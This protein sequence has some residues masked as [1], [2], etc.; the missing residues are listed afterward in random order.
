MVK[1]QPSENSES[2]ENNESRENNGNSETDRE[3]VIPVKIVKGAAQ[4]TPPPA[5][6][7]RNSEN[8]QNHLRIDFEGATARRGDPK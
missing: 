1:R 2:S 6:P 8:H 5:P 3:L 7:S 4:Q